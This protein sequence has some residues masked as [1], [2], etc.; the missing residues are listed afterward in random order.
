MARGLRR[1]TAAV[2]SRFTASGR[3]DCLRRVESRLKALEEPLVELKRAIRY[4]AAHVRAGLLDYDGADIWMRLGSFREFQRMRSCRSEPWTVRWIEEW[5]GPG[6][7][8][9]D[10][11]ANVGAYT[12]V[13]ACKP[14]GGARVYAFEPGSATYAALVEN[15]MLNAVT[16]TVTALPVA[17]GARTELQE[18]GLSQ[19]DA[20]AAMH[21]VGGADD[22]AGRQ[23]ILVYALDEFVR[24]FDLPRPAH[25][26]LDVDGLEHAVLEG[27]TG[28]LGD[29][30]LRT[31]LCELDAADEARIVE[32][33]TGHG[34][35]LHERFGREKPAS[36]VQPPAYGLFVRQAA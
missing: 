34:F 15:L 2:T 33:L 9:Y 21:T 27:A 6:E 4:D 1:T 3:D 19:L 18:L 22:E 26:K 8:L 20:G 24:Q 14:G 10:L 23:H 7:V 30:S 32:T 36:A 13:A 25:V 31:V 12:L 17:L 28:L 5:I 16:G 11:G 29:P 35:T